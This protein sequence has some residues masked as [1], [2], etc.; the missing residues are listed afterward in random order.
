MLM[1]LSFEVQPQMRKMRM[2]VEE[3]TIGGDNC[4]S[5]ADGS[6]ACFLPFPCYR[7][8]VVLNSKCDVDENEH[9]V[10]GDL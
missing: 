3:E 8:G 10:A 5:F 6:G 9:G 1:L 7:C 2:L 4:W